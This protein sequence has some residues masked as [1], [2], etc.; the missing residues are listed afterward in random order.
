MSRTDCGGRGISCKV[1]QYCEQSTCK[2]YS[3]AVP[4]GTFQVPLVENQSNPSK[5]C[6]YVAYKK[7]DGTVHAGKPPNDTEQS[8]HLSAVC[9]SANGILRSYGATDTTFFPNEYRNHAGYECCISEANARAMLSQPL[10]QAQTQPQQGQTQSQQGQTQPQQG[11]TQSQKA[12]IQQRPP[13]GAR[14][15]QQACVMPKVLGIP[16][17]HFW[18]AIGIL[19][20]AIVASVLCLRQCKGKVHYDL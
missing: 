20:L 7:T 12:Q 1:D 11:Q 16:A 2:P 13:S 6:S 4:F 17:V 9:T 15:E 10:L 5:V 8:R 3:R 18:S 19:V 14:G